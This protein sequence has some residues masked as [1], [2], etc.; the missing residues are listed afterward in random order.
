MLLWGLTACHRDD[1]SAFQGYVEGDYVR[2]AAPVGGRLAE[3]NVERG[4]NVEKDAPLFSLEQER[5][6]AAV[7][8]A[9]ER[10]N[11][12]NVQ[13]QL[14]QTQLRR[15]NDLRKR[16]LSTVEQYDIAR[17]QADAAKG[18]IDELQAQRDQATWQLQ[19]RTQAAGAA[20]IVDEIYFR[21]GE[22]VPAGAPVV[23][24][25][26]PE[27]RRIRFF[28]PESI[29]G[30]IKAGQ[31][32]SASCDGCGAAIAGHVIFI[33]PTVEFTPPV[34]YSR[35]QRERLM[36]LVEALPDASAATRLHPGQPLDVTL[37]P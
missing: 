15:Q 8:E 16:G 9:D 23:S 32:I 31:G 1:S 19:Q 18:R 20:G 6:R 25:L 28:V 2:V 37:A 35:G 24:L 30:G 33:S 13:L 12:A 5:E 3:L 29:A 14:S 21:P 34:I 4:A 22:W 17:A 11:Q 27:N 26:P 10:L 36:F 7:T